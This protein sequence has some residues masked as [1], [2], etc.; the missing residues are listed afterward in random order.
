ML[1]WVEFGISIW[2]PLS[3]SIYNSLW[4]F[5]IKNYSNVLLLT[6]VLPRW[7]VLQAGKHVLTQHSPYTANNM[8]A[9]EHYMSSKPKR[10]TKTDPYIHTRA[11]HT[12][13]HFH[14]FSSS[15]S[16]T[17]PIPYAR[18]M[19]RTRG[20]QAQPRAAPG[21]TS[22]LG[23]PPVRAEH[24][25]HHAQHRAAP[26]P[27]A[28][29]TADAP[30][31]CCWRAESDRLGETALPPFEGT[32]PSGYGMD[33]TPPEGQSL[34]EPY[35]PPIS[36]LYTDGSGKSATRRAVWRNVF[37]L[38]ISQLCN[39]RGKGTL[40]HFHLGLISEPQFKFLLQVAEQRVAKA[41]Q[42]HN[43]H[44]IWQDD[45]EQYKL[46]WGKKWTRPLRR[47]SRLYS[48]HV[49]SHRLPLSSCD[50]SVACC[51]RRIHTKLTDLRWWQT[52]RKCYM[53]C[54]CYN[55]R[56]WVHSVTAKLYDRAEE[57]KSFLNEIL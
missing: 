1:Q 12:T 57:K 53:W 36:N 32:T 10:H 41:R 38:A 39:G 20:E 47:A 7:D 49:R 2:I 42:R 23:E 24:G 37:H 44:N 55:G 29:G 34:R 19:V 3:V 54:K 4:A 26:C 6:L 33:W 18:S 48:C 16:L 9:P 21:G 28:P 15:S 11:N 35:A 50:F 31:R 43:S 22:P 56:L 8:E 25:P 30:N 52:P 51:R 17:P 5:K 46:E 45:A 13:F 14:F 27:G 40:T